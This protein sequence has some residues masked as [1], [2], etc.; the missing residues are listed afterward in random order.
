MA[1]DLIKVAGTIVIKKNGIFIWK[2]SNLVTTLGEQL[3]ATRLGSNSPMITH[4]ALGSGTGAPSKADTALGSE[5]GRK[6]V[7]F[8]VNGSTAKFVSTFEAGVATGSL[9]EAGLF[10]A[11]TGGLLTN[12]VVFPLVLKPA[13][14][15]LEVTWELEISEA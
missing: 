2:Q 14:D 12:R 4:M 9:T 1:K 11:A 13:D 15:Q 8:S 7:T 10:S 6:A 5:L 3:V